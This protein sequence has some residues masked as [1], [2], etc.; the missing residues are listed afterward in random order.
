MIQNSNSPSTYKVPGS[1]FSC[2]NFLV[3][4]CIACH[5]RHHPCVNFILTVTCSRF[6]HSGWLWLSFSSLLQAWWMIWFAL[7]RSLY[8]R[9]C[10]A[11]L[12]SK[13]QHIVRSVHYHTFQLKRLQLLW[14]FGITKGV[15]SNHITVRHSQL[16]IVQTLKKSGGHDASV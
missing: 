14:L 6:I 15:D 9:L 5:L 13:T 10:H 7:K 1:L 8:W 12:S 4:M 3:E 2:N 11:V 16:F